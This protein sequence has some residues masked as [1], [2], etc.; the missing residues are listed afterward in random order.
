[1]RAGV[2]ALLAI[3]RRQ[4][5]RG[6]PGELVLRERA[7]EGVEHRR[8]PR[9][10]LEVDQR[11]AGVVLGQRPDLRGG[12]G[13]R[14][15]QEVIGGRP[16][17]LGLVGLLALLVDRRRQVLDHGLPRLVVGRR[18][19]EHARIGVLGLRIVAGLEGRVGDDRPRPAAE[20][21]IRAGIAVDQLLRRRDRRRK[22]LHLVEIVYRGAEHGGCVL[23]FRERVDEAQRAGD[24]VAPRRRLLPGRRALLVLPLRVDRRLS[25]RRRLLVRGIVVGG[26]LVLPRRLGEVLVLEQQIG[27]PAVDAGRSRIRGEGGEVGAVPA[28]RL[29]EVLRPL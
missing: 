18:H 15:P 16:V 1:G 14:D 28:R 8:G 21:R 27:E 20:R 29:L 25:G 3:D 9:P 6:L 12:C 26:A 5:L 10:V 17:V 24:G 22:L 23:V 13:L 2:V 4:L 19:L 7:P 11:R